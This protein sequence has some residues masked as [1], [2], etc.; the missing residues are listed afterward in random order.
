MRDSDLLLRPATRDDWPVVAAL[1]HD[2][3]NA[4][5]EAHGMRA[6]FPAGPASTLL[7]CEQYEALDPGGCLVAEDTA[8]GAI[9]GSCFW[10]KRQTHASLGIMN[11]H[12]EAF[13]RSVARHLLDAICAM[14]DEAGL[15]TRLVSSALNLDSYSL[16]TRAGFVPRTLYQDMVL[17]ADLSG[18][19][20]HGRVRAATPEDLPRIVALARELEG[21]D[22]ERDYGHFLLDGSDLWHVSVLEGAGGELDGAL[23]SIAH[24][25]ST[26]LGPGVARTDDAAAALILAELRHR[27]GQRP[28]VLVPAQRQ[29]LV[30][31]L[32]SWGARNVELHVHQCRGAWTPP[33]GISFPTFM[34]ESA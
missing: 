10:R 17:P 13:G 19:E 26:M 3:T 30:A 25:A 1:I 34:P 6:V 11:V 18:V 20:A 32:Y 33:A 5:Y 23:A 28:V 29:G 14:A 7:F 4:W 16:Y 21:L 15:P 8:S 12:P 2:S 31:T 27:A 24:P 9:V 22:R